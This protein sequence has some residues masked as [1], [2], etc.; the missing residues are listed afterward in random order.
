VPPPVL[1]ELSTGPRRYRELRPPSPVYNK[2]ERDNLVE[3]IEARIIGTA[4]KIAEEALAGCRPEDALVAANGALVLNEFDQRAVQGPPASLRRAGAY[5]W[6]GGA[7]TA[8]EKAFTDEENFDPETTEIYTLLMKTLQV[9]R[10][11]HR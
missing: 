6:H 9:P 5:G 3:A 11:R 2:R 7:Y 8:A 10:G 4:V 1:S